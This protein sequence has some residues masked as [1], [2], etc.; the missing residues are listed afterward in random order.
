MGCASTIIPIK[1][2]IKQTQCFILRTKRAHFAL[3][4]KKQISQK[5]TA[6]LAAIQG[7]LRFEPI[8]RISSMAFARLYTAGT[9][10]QA[11]P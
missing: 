7:L 3:N 2:S 9:S 8:R 11:N 5:P 10:P 4:I 6:A 1:L